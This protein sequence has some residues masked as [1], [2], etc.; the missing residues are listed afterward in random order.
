MN[1]E[2]IERYQAY[3]NNFAETSRNISKQVYCLAIIQEWL[4]YFKDKHIQIGGDFPRVD[5]ENDSAAIDR[6]SKTAEY[7]I[8]GRKDLQR[9]QQ[10]KDLSNVEGI[11]YN[12]DSTYKVALVKNKNEYRDYAAVILHSKTKLWRQGQVKFELKQQSPDTFYC[13]F[14]YRNHHPEVA[15]YYF[16]NGEFNKGDWI[17]EGSAPRIAEAKAYVQHDSVPFYARKITR[18]TLY[19]RILSFNGEYAKTID[20]LFM[21]NELL[22]KKTPNLILDLR[23]N[24]GGSDYSYG[25]ILPYLYTNPIITVGVDVLASEDN[26]K[27]WESLL[28]ENNFPADIKSELAGKI[29]QMKAHPNQYV[30]IAPDDTTA[31]AEVLPYPQ[32][33]AILI[34]KSC[35]SA[36]EQFLLAAKQSSKVTLFGEHTAG[37]LDY[38]NMRAKEFPC[39]PFKL[40]Y[41]TTRSRRIPKY[42]IDNIGI[43]PDIVFPKNT[44]WIELTIE[45][46]EK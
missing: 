5:D 26:I 21:Q 23:G 41:A 18:K 35:A 10:Q 34:D 3:T 42:A 14:Y 1:A 29:A 37:V 4:K 46:L 30:N 25:P 36:T 24:S 6:I 27:S 44:D 33:V 7:L 20:S 11:Y 22:I 15:T 39:M 43:Q 38:S 31:Y 8:V 40:Y 13:I 45:Y 16:V 17:R 32:K 12:Q 2:S 19:L 28:A 9:I